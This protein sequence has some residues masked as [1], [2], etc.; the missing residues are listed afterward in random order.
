MWDKK[1]IDFHIKTNKLLDKIKDEA[2][3]YV[4]VLDKNHTL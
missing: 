3:D 2:F 4:K 1:I